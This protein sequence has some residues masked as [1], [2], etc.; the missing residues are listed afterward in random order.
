M[1]ALSGG[2]HPTIISQGNRFVALEDNNAKEV[3][4]RNY[5]PESEWSKWIWRSEGD[6]LLNGARFRTSGPLKSPH[7]EFTKM[8]MIDAKPATFV[9][10]LTKFTGAIECKKGETVLT[11]ST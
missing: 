11:G 2:M 7:Y 9:G 5:A 10:K 4:N 3:T 1:Y 8:E 6:L